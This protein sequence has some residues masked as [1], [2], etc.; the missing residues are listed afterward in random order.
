MA[1]RLAYLHDF[2]RVPRLIGS[3]VVGVGRVDVGSFSYQVDVDVTLRVGGHLD[4]EHVGTG[5]RGLQCQHL[6]L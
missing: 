2:H 3:V 4:V 5:H 6:G 1:V